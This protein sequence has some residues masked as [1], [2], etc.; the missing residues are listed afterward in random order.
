DFGDISIDNDEKNKSPESLVNTTTLTADFLY[1]ILD[2]LTHPFYIIDVDDYTIKMANSA[3]MIGQLDETSKCHLIIHRSPV[4]CWE[5]GYDCPVFE[6]KKTKKPVILEHTHFDETGDLRLIEVHA[7]PV[8]D[9]DDNVVQIINSA[10]DI[11]DQKWVEGQ[12]ATESRRARLY[13]DLLAHDMSNELQV[14]QGSAEL[15]KEVMTTGTE[16][17]MLYQFVHQIVESVNRCMTLISEARST[18]NLAIAPLVERSVSRALLDCAETIGENFSNCILVFEGENLDAKVLA[19]KY[20]E[21]LFIKIISNAVKH[22]LSDY[23]IV[24]IRLRPSNEGYEISISDNGPGIEDV[25]KEVLFDPKH[26][27]GGLGIHFSLQIVEKYGGK[28]SIRDRIH[29]HPNEGVE[30][31]IWLPKLRSSDN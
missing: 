27:F 6:I 12:L 23:R 26:R 29:G 1:R 21:N 5:K 22:N 3:A 11:T 31:V 9:S 13:L 24:W 20:L 2:S 16:S 28:I 15:A 19:D 25:M 4:P 17:E 14:I 10:L 8:I 18:E 7:Y 30:F